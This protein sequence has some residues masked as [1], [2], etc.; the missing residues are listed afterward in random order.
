MSIDY[1]TVG[2]KIRTLRIRQGLSQFQLSE[3]IDVSPPYISNIENGVKN[4]SIETLVK[5]A[6]A[7]QVSIDELLDNNLNN[8]LIASARTFEVVLADCNEYEKRI[9]LEM[10]S[11]LKI[12][13]RENSM[14]KPKPRK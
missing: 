3:M 4:A 5:I 14:Y 9:L 2:N 13:L 8:K 10:V 6:N 1:I 12:A 11:A 7:L